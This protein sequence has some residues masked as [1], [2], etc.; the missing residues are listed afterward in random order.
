MGGC[1][2][3]KKTKMVVTR[4]AAQLAKALGWLRRTEPKFPC[5]A[6]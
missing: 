5:A 2:G 3:V 6:S 4:T 1:A